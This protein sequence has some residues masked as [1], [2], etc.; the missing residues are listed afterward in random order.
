MKGRI[1]EPG[2]TLD[3]VLEGLAE[4]Y[5]GNL[6]EHG[7]ASRSVGWKDESSQRL[8]FH[9]LAELVTEDAVRAGFTVNDLGCGYGAMFR[10]LDERFGAGLAHWRGYDISGEMLRAAR[11]FA[12]DS[13]VE[14]VESPRLLHRADYS[15]VS[16]T[17]NVKLHAEDDAWRD[18]VAATLLHLRDMSERGFALNLLS[19]YVDWRAENLFYGDPLYFFDFCK[20]NISRRV[21]LLHDYPLYE[22]TLLVRMES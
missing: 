1:D 11:G 16:G 19:T 14:L 17:F 5:T 2:G 8:R 4:L 21:T 20:R 18:H 12:A 6:R 9:K 15:F 10:Y 13:R 7:L 22:W 3:R